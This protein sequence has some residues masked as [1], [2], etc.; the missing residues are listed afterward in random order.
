[1]RGKSVLEKRIVGSPD[2]IAD[3]IEQC[4]TITDKYYPK[5]ILE[6][7]CRCS[8]ILASGYFRLFLLCIS[9]YLSVNF[10]TVDS[11]ASFFFYF[12]LFPP[13]KHQQSLY[14]DSP[15]SI[16]HILLLLNICVFFL[17]NAYIFCS[18][19]NIQMQMSSDN[20]ITIF[21]INQKHGHPI[22]Q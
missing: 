11:L 6:R 7:R 10:R 5:Y 12:Y 9:G 15:P 3:S 17:S 14:T 18:P 20:I 22:K 1:M 2:T 4:H 16:V 19:A 21:T 13:G 8:K